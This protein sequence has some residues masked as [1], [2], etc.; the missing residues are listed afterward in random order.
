MPQRH[1]VTVHSLNSY[2]GEA[3]MGIDADDSGYVSVIVSSHNS[4][5]VTYLIQMHDGFLLKLIQFDDIDWAKDWFTKWQNWVVWAKEV[6]HGLPPIISENEDL[7][8]VYIKDI[9]WLEELVL[10]DD[11]VQCPDIKE[12]P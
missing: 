11:H 8:M 6:C 7:P 4:P 5:T 1:H 3:F 12:G 10:P 9:D 2:N